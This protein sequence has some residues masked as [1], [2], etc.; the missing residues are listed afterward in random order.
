MQLT[1]TD[2]T[3]LLIPLYSGV[4]DQAAWRTFLTRIQRR[5]GA[6]YASLIFAQGDTPIHLSKEVFSGRDLRGEARRQG[7]EPLYEK[8]RL[9]YDRLRP[10]RV[11]H[12]AEFAVSDARFREFHTIFNRTLGLSDERIVRIKEQEG[13]NAW[14][15]LA[16]NQQAFSA[17]D[18]ALLTAVV[19]H[20]TVAL[21]SFVL[22]ERA[23]IRAAINRD[24][25]ARAGVG[26]IALSREGRII[27][28]DP[29]LAPLLREAHG[30][31]KLLGERLHVDSARDRQVMVQ[32]ARLYAGDPHA[33]T[34]AIR[35]SEE[36]PLDALLIPMADQPEAALT[37]PV[38]LAFCCVPRRDTRGRQALLGDL[39]GLSPREAELALAM[40]DGQTISE[41]AAAMGLTEET[42]RGYSKRIYAKMGVRGQAELVRRIFLS[43]VSL[44]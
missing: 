32:A 18:S 34:R 8:D 16:R 11:Y 35:V 37:L 1:S 6:D 42:A 28:I 36:P 23:R 31:D 3:D 5:T 44:A 30:S 41:A 43:I 25:L 33:P 22:V 40:S 29:R 26:W 2:E 19:P 7:L 39:F 4:H 38:M 27:D 9:P 21:R 24:A 15:M 13:T 17:T 14:L 20:V 10:G 12:S